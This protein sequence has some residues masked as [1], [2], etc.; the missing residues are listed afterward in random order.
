MRIFA[1]AFFIAAAS[2]LFLAGISIT[3]AATKCTSIQARCALEIGGHCNPKTGR[4]FYGNYQGQHAGGNTQTFDN[5]IS[6]ETAR[7]K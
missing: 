3:F 7:K 1:L 5:C 6:R 2:A 4:W